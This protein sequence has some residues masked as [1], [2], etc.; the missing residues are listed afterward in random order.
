MINL[1]SRDLVG[2]VR[3][4]LAALVFSLLAATQP[5]ALSQ[6]C[7][8]VPSASTTAHGGAR[9]SIENGES[10][11]AT[12]VTAN[13]EFAQ[14]EVLSAQR[15][16]TTEPAWD[17]P[18]AFSDYVAQLHNI[19]TQLSGPLTPALCGALGSSL[20]AARFEFENRVA[21]A[22]DWLAIAR[23]STL[24]DA[25]QSFQIPER[26]VK[27]IAATEAP[28]Y[29]WFT[30]DDSVDRAVSDFLNFDADSDSAST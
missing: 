14:R 5:V 15:L 3:S 4:G 11:S 1:W 2:V 19:V 17:A 27:R 16:L 20:L 28:P 24:A 6:G 25:D 22:R 8:E 13:V 9:F 18:A 30:S 7:S 10:P 21:S 29:T 12:S 26:F 23:A